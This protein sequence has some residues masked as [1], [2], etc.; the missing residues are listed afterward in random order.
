[1]TIALSDSVAEQRQRIAECEGTWWR[2]NTAGFHMVDY[3]DARHG[4]SSKCLVFGD[5]MEEEL[6]DERS[7]VSKA[8]P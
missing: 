4:Q 5:G 8:N 6:T 1:M 3:Q 2:S 7:D